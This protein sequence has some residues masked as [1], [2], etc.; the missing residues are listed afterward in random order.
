MVSRQ[1][2]EAIKVALAFT[3]AYGISLS[4]GWLNPQW[5]GFAVAMTA[6]TSAGPS[7]HK[8]VLRVLGTIPGCLAALVIFAIA[9]QDRWLFLL[10]ACLWVFFTTYNMLRNPLNSYF[11]QVAGFVCLVILLTDPSSPQ[12]VFS[13][14]MA[15]VIETTMGVTVYTL[16]SVFL[17]PHKTTGALKTANVDLLSTQI[18]RFNR[19]TNSL[20][21]FPQDGVVRVKNNEASQFSQLPGLLNSESI[22]DYEVKRLQ[23]SWQS[24]H[25]LAKE[26]M[27]TLDRWQSGSLFANQ[28]SPG[29]YVLNQAD[30]FAEITARLNATRETLTGKKSTFEPTTVTPRYNTAHLNNLSHS[31]RAALSSIKNEIRH[32]D[33]L[34]RDMLQTANILAGNQEPASAPCFSL[35]RKSKMTKF[36][37]PIA[38]LDHLKGAGLVSLTL[39]ASYLVWILFDPPGHMAWIQ[40]PATIAML[41]A[42]IQQLRAITMVKSLTISLFLAI[43]VYVFV[44]PHLSSFFGLGITLF[45]CMFLTRYYL[46]GMDQI[47]GSIAILTM[48]SI[49][50][51][52]AYNFSAMANTILFIVFS[53]LFAYLCSYAIGSA[54]PEKVYLK[55]LR[56]FFRSA[57]FLSSN[58]NL[59]SHQAS[60]LLQRWLI[61]FHRYELTNLPV[62]IAAW[63]RPI[64]HQFFSNNSAASVQSIVDSLQ[65]I[66]YRIE[67]LLSLN[68]TL[69]TTKLPTEVYRQTAQW[70]D[71]ITQALV[72]WQN[73]PNCL[74]L[75]VLKEQLDNHLQST[76]AEFDALFD[77]DR[78]TLNETIQDEHYYQLL[79]SFKNLSAAIIDHAEVAEAIDWQQWQEERFS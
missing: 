20:T 14:A 53:F 61:K 2:K 36:Q 68:E 48:L 19:I 50:N 69:A 24:Y 63:G 23:S 56:R 64:D 57:A 4:Q 49:D 29:S 62:K 55:Q 16:V 66:R 18:D 22:E 41:I 37:L 44:M 59:S 13:Q 71:S 38:D 46:S 51:Q 15:R 31:D 26:L 28:I 27:I 77:T 32:I 39:I 33:R 75:I 12:T 7:L 9:A 25:A 58:I 67:R 34:T 45:T 42:Q 3:M 73:A 54:R 35:A 5:A 47:L 65:T 72:D 11:W 74:N 1:A 6:L 30:F 40:L 43:S 52:Q 17:W 60:K 70:R 78:E 8:G 79:I 76:E 21:H 10:L